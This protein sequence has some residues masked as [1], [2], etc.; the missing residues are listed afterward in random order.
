MIRYTLSC[1]NQHTFEHW[2]DN[3]ADADGKLADHALT[4][5]TCGDTNIRKSLMA[6]NLGSG[7]T[8]EPPT[9]SPNA[10]ASCPAALG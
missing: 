7:K 3:M 8:P 1:A 9:C 10:C 2:F 4:C 6:P 5:P